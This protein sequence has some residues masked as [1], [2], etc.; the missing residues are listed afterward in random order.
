M[1]FPVAINK[2]TTLVNNMTSLS[3][4]AAAQTTKLQAKLEIL[5]AAKQAIKQCDAIVRTLVFILNLSLALSNHITF[6]C[7]SFC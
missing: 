5:G 4:L 2:L 6:Y 3:K 1:F 7:S